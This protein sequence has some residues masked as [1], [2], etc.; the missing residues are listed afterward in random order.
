MAAVMGRNTV[1]VVLCSL[2]AAPREM[3]AVALGDL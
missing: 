2:P 3:G 1:V